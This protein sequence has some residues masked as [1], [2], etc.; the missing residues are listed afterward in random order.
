MSEPG[1]GVDP[2]P[3]R[4]WWPGGLRRHY[5]VGDGSELRSCGV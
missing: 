5:P 1:T 4:W 3:P 2:N